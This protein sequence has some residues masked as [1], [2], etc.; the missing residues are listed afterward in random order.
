MI[1]TQYMSSPIGQITLQASHKG[2]SYIGFHP[3]FAIH[4]ENNGHLSCAIEQLT[5]YFKGDLT[6]FDV[7]LDVKGTPFQKAVWEVLKQV[8]FGES[9]TYGW[10]ANQLDNPKAVRAV[11]AA[12]GK[13][14]ISF[15]VPCH[16]IIGQNG[17]LTGY[18]G[19]IEAKAWLLSHERIA[20]K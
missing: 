2:I 10:I 6:V 5:A 17:T 9:R 13:N 20:F 16:R 19:G 4:E 11:G 8:P 12:N 14:P 18:A 1:V 7:K 3:L 15:I